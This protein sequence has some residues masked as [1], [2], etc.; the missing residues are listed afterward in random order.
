VLLSGDSDN[1][2]DVDIHD[3]TFLLYRWGLPPQDGGCPWDGTRDADFSLDGA[4]SSPDY[5]IVSANWLQLTTCPCSAKTP[6]G[7]NGIVATS[8]D[9][10]ALPAAVVARTDLNEDGIIDAEDVRIFEAREGLPNLLSTRMRTGAVVRPS[11]D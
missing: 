1:D 9:A 10:A 11:R 2:S 7:S 3:V 4:V 6:G 5:V 8:I